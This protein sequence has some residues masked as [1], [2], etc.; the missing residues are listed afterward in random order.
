MRRGSTPKSLLSRL[1]RGHGDHRKWCGLSF[2]R[3]AISAINRTRLG[4][5]RPSPADRGFSYL[6]LDA[7]YEKIR[8]AAVIRRS[9]GADRDRH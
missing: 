6:V 5:V 1:T 7:R 2:S 8:Q 9:G 3:S 4:P